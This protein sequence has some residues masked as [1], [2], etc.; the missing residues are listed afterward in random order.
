MGVRSTR[1]TIRCPGTA[2]LRP[3]LG[4]E[5]MEVMLAAAGDRARVGFGRPR[6][7]QTTTARLVRQEGAMQDILF[8]VEDAENGSDRARAAAAAIH[9]QA[10]TLSS[11][12]GRSQPRSSVTSILVGRHP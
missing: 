5:A 11:S 4:L 1:P 12:T 6:R 9:T 3:A 7:L 8:V 2:W 10:D